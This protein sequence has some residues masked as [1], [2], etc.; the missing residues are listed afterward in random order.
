MLFLDTFPPDAIISSG[1][2]RNKGSGLCLPGG[3]GGQAWFAGWR[4]VPR[5]FARDA[6]Q[7]LQTQSQGSIVF[8][9]VS[10]QGGQQ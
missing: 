1:R 6:L 3:R 8:T 2:K 5:V 10:P 9:S 4:L 7:T